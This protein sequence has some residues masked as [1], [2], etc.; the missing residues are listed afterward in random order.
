MRARVKR[1]LPGKPSHLLPFSI[2]LLFMGCVKGTQ[3]YTSFFGGPLFETRLE[4]NMVAWGPTPSFL[5]L[6]NESL[7]SHPLTW[8]LPGE[9]GGVLV[10]TIIF[11]KG[12]FL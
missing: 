1:E 9:G 3:T 5:R 12:P 10:W 8:S 6:G 2:W 7:P 4:D 11:L